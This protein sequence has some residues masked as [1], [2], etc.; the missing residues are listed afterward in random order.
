MRFKSLTL[1]VILSCILV[2]G[3]NQSQTDKHGSSEIKNADTQNNVL[4]EPVVKPHRYYVYRDGS[5]FGYEQAL[6]KNDIESGRATLPLMLISYQGKQNNR[7]HFILIEGHGITMASC[8]EDCEMIEIQTRAG[9][10]V[11]RAAPGS[12][13]YAIASDMKNGFL[14]PEPVEKHAE[15]LPS[16]EIPQ[17]PSPAAPRADLPS[18]SAPAAASQH[19]NPSFDCS[20]AKSQVELLICQDQQLSELDADLE[21]KFLQ[22]RYVAK[23]KTQF[24]LQARQEWTWREQNCKDK[25]CL[26]RWYQKRAQQLEKVIEEE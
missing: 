1:S 14:E 9:I 25:A 15:K 21:E 20:K 2:S 16:A 6:S 19:Y 26:L 24:R 11:M 8:K 18:V 22:A 7:Y 23:D 13:L 10:Q 4:T 3:C 12:I 17:Q 5:R